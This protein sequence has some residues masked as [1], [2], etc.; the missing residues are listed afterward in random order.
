MS[1]TENNMSYTTVNK[2]ES[3]F[4]NN[5]GVEQIFIKTNNNIEDD[6]QEDD[7]DEDDYQEDDEE[8]DDDDE[9]EDEEDED[10]EV[11]DQRWNTL[12]KLLESQL[13]ISKA[14]L[15][16]SDA[17]LILLRNPN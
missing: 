6:Y 7:D 15:Q 5:I 1:D 17:L 11:E 10:E 2:N 14:Q 4:H 16:I 9:D 12:D 13:Q 8:E 3:P